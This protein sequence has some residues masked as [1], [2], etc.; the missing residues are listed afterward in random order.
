MG[1]ATRSKAAPL[2]AIPEDAEVE[3]PSSEI[4]ELIEELEKQGGSRRCAPAWL[5]CRG[6]AWRALNAALAPH[7][8]S[9][10]EGARHPGRVERGAVPA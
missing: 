10:G 6:R 2:L 8:R 1:R 7:A 5:P 4:L 9:G 3:G